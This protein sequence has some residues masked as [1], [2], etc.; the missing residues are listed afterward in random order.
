M[1]DVRGVELR[2]VK[3]AFQ[4]ILRPRSIVAIA[5]MFW[6]AGA[7]C[8]MVSYARGA[9]TR[10]DAPAQSAPQAMAGMSA[11]MDAHACCK[12]RHKSSQQSADAVDKA[13]G[14]ELVQTA[15]PPSSSSEAMSCCPLTSGSIVI[16]S[17]SQSTDDNSVLNHTGSSSLQLTKTKSPPL[18]VPLRPPNRARAY[19][20]DCAFLI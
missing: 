18:A 6:C 5:L 4:Q 9:M 15:L 3:T 19:L 1:L 10:M 20:L 13:S 8:M 12:A 11:S 17:R 7:G 2:R 16:A 14:L